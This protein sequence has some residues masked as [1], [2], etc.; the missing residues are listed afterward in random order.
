MVDA[1][2]GSAKTVDRSIESFA[3]D[4]DRRAARGRNRVSRL[5]SRTLFSVFA[6][7]ADLGVI[8]A[9]AL[10]IGWSYH[11]LVFDASGIREEVIHLGMMIALIFVV[12]TASRGDYALGEHLSLKGRVWPLFRLWSIAFAAA[13]ILA[14]LTKTSINFSRGT[15]LLFYGGGFLVLFGVRSF[16]VR[17]VQ[18]GSKTGMLAARRIFLIGAESEVGAFIKRHQPWNLGLEVAGVAALPASDGVEAD[19]DEAV[20]R[21]R[22]VNAD[23]VFILV[24]WDSAPLMDAIIDRLLTVPANIH[25]GGDD[26]LDRFD[27]MRVSR[28]G[29]LASMQIVHGPLSSTDL[30]VKRALDFILASAALF[31]LAP[32]FAVIALL[33]KLDSPGP[34][35]FKQRRFG[36]NQQM[37][38]I[39]KFRTMRTLDDGQ[40]VRQATKDDPRVTRVGRFLRRWSLDELPQIINVLR[41]EMSLVGPRPHALAHDREY[42]QKIALYARRHNVM[43]GI[44]G[45]AQV[46]G[47]RG[48]TSSDDA[49]RARVD[50]DLH[51][52]D[53]WS[54]ML[55]IKILFLTVFSR[56]VHRN[57]R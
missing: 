16:L 25:L 55:D 13:I 3:G 27:D 33:I 5:W 45:W 1:T 54:L 9:S 41:G 22:A 11:L 12:A 53:N 46:N 56:R 15:V 51:Y 10:I 26:L 48:E 50:H 31:A 7:A 34:V 4:P 17:L 29:S 40:V 36:F 42:E 19:L 57:A 52:I 20:A 38:R 21:V 2:I 32:V 39:V 49:M 8:V 24:P 28:I 14:F 47:Y 30:V 35:L 23:D 44:T 18:V 37:F 6:A 43:P